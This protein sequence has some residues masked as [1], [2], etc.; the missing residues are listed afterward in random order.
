MVKD[1]KAQLLTDYIVF[2]LKKAES[3]DDIDS[4]ETWSQ[5]GYDVNSFTT[6]AQMVS[7]KSNFLQTEEELA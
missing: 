1:S 6:P 2:T 5:L 7:L 3:M 4:E